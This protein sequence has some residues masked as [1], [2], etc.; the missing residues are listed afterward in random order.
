MTVFI[1]NLPWNVVEHT[2]RE[3]FRERGEIVYFRLS[4]DR[5][6]GDFTGYGHAEFFA[7][8]DKAVALAKC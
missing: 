3:I 6:S 4:I 1:G 8:A 2:I 5:E 7:M